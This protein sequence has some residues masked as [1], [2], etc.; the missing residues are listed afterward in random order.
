M[1]AYWKR[2]HFKNRKMHFRVLQFFLLKTAR[3]LS[4]EART[5][6]L[7]IEYI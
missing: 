4:V 2:T 6:T 3:R 5:T 7:Q 1:R